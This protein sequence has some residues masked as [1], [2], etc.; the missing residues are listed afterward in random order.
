MPVRLTAAQTRTVD[1]I[2]ADLASPRQMNRIL[3]GDVGSGKTA[4]AFLGDSGARWNRARRR[5]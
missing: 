5:S 3:I 1:E 4:V 2:A